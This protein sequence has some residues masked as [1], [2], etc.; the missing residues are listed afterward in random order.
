MILHLYINI[1]IISF[2]LLSALKLKC[3]LRSDSCL[4]P[5]QNYYVSTY[6][7]LCDT[8]VGYRNGT[9]K[10]VNVKCLILRIP[11]TLSG[12]ISFTRGL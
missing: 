3:K 8:V 6:L 12:L 7:F 5:R 4:P 11:G 1:N 9:Y 10:S 2:F